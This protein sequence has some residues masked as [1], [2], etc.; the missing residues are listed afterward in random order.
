MSGDDEL[1]VVSYNIFFGKLNTDSNNDIDL[2]IQTLCAQILS[3]DADVVCLQEVLPDRLERIK[4]LTSHVYPYANPEHVIQSYDTVILSRY[5]FIKKAKINFSISR[6]GRSI[7]WVC[8]KSPIDPKRL[9][10]IA[11]SHLESEFGNELSEQNTK[12]MQYAEAEDILNQVAMACNAN[13]IIF[14]GDFNA[15]NDLS[16]DLLIKYFTY[17]N[18]VDE[19]GWKDSWIEFGSDSAKECTFDSTS[20]PMLIQMHSKSEN[21][22]RYISRLDRIL[23]KSSLHVQSF[24]MIRSDLLISDHYPIV[25]DFGMHKPNNQCDYSENLAKHVSR[26]KLSS[27]SASASSKVSDPKRTKFQK[28]SLFKPR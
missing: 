13:D 3:L 17:Q 21:P 18:S 12:T 9:I 15:H 24:D 27:Q 7:N 23:H 2:R 10:G 22:P 8:I 28:V 20:N 6:M 19:I 5:P 14:C 11:N 16:D 26:I 1:R 25:V 4:Y